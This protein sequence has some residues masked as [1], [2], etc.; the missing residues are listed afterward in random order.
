MKKWYAVSTFSRSEITAARDIFRK[1]ASLGMSQHFS[2]I[3][4][5]TQKNAILTPG[6]VYIEMEYDNSLRNAIRTVKHVIDF[7]PIIK[8]EVIDIVPRR[9]AEVSTGYIEYRT[10]VPISQA[11]MNRILSISDKKHLIDFN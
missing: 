10:P 6:V 3:F 9:T 7:L 11:E 8:S 2:R 4:V 5:P 1:M